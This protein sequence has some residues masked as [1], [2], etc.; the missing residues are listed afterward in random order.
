MIADND[1][2]IECYIVEL[3]E[4]KKMH[5]K[6]IFLSYYVD[7]TSGIYSLFSVTS[8]STVSLVC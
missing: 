5:L 3:M 1:S 4:I 2:I 6:C 8:A 7:F